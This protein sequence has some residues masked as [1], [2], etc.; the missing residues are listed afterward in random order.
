MS[1]STIVDASG[2][3]AAVGTGRTRASTRLPLRSP[4]PPC[5]WRAST[6]TSASGFML[7]CPPCATC[8]PCPARV[9]E[10]ESRPSLGS[11][12]KGSTY[13]RPPASSCEYD[14]ISSL[15]PR[16]G[17]GNTRAENWLPAA[18]SSSAGSC[19][20]CRKSSYACRALCFS[21]TSPSCHSSPS[22][23]EK[24]LSAAPSGSVMPNV[25]SSRR[26]SGFSKT[27][28]SSV[29]ASGSS[30]TARASSSAS[31]SPVPLEAVRLNG[32]AGGA[33]ASGAPSGKANAGRGAA[34]GASWA[35]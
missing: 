5:I 10:Y 32:G 27:S 29:N 1:T 25:P 22:F 24:R 18:C 33:T 3:G 17:M 11:P 23:M 4:A 2:S 20:R 7:L 13:G 30:T 26:S 28:R 34:L 12:R 9:T 6:C 8:C 16:A 31:R 35:S 14:T 21:T 19:R 15:R